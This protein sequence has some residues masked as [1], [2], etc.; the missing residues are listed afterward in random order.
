[1]AS[2]RV[3]IRLPRLSL[4]GKF[5]VAS[6]IP[7]VLLG[8]VLAKTLQIQIRNQALT[9]ARQ[10]AATIARLDIQPQLTPDDLT[11]GL[12]PERLRQL[13]HVLH[14]GL[15]GEEIARVKIWSRD[16]RVVYS[17]DPEL[18]GRAFPPSHELEDALDGQIV[19]EVSDLTKEEN[20]GDRSY[21]K[22]LE[23]YVPLT[24]P[25]D[26]A[27]AGAFELYLPYLPIEAAV[28]RDSHRLY[29]VLLGGLA[30]LYV[31][32]FRIVATASRR[33]RRQAD[34]ELRLANEERDLA[35]RK[36]AVI[37]TVSHEFRTPLTIIE[38]VSST[39][40]RHDLVAGDGHSLLDSLLNA[41]HRLHDLVED[42]L[43][44][45]E[46]IERQAEME[47][48]PVALSE[49][50]QEV[51]DGLSSF[52]AHS[53]VRVVAIADGDTV[54]SDPAMLTPLLRHI[55]ENALKFSPPGSAVDISIARTSG[56]VEVRVRDRGPGIDPEFM[57]RAFDPFT[58]EDQS[59]TRAKSGLGIGL[60]AARKIADLIGGRVELQRHPEGGMEA[61]LHLPDSVEDRGPVT[62]EVDAG[63]AAP[64][65]WPSSLIGRS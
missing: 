20:V 22:L 65:A 15:V 9:N 23:V 37:A 28:A 2:S 32:L 21:G 12:T 56:E 60:F 30:L 63:D 53:R 44:T 46:G 18:I 16:L 6:L 10:L 59:S 41:S 11:R 49:V 48:R 24:F 51:V 8:L 40:Q 64:V 43:A 26:P 13:D 36:A 35:L 38:G 31:A 54:M 1:V 47:R 52:D 7:I 50:I 58:Q 14:A 5:A 61:I 42:L 39:L 19:S 57:E 29:L 55:I 62:A 27:P 17:D 4:L 33:L 34:R 45:A 3:A 25:G